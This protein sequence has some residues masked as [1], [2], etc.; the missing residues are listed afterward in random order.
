ME[1]LE[2]RARQLVRALKNRGEECGLC[3]GPSGRLVIIGP[4][5]YSTAAAPTLYERA[6]L[7]KA[8]A[9]GLVEPAKIRLVDKDKT[10]E[11]DGY[12]AS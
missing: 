6:D 10:V 8:I 5:R 9:L 3:V 2:E 1:A 4:G 11:I 12:L 7:E